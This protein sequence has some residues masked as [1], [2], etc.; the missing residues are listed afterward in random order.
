[1]AQDLKLNVSITGDF[2]GFQNSLNGLQKNLKSFGSSVE[3]V[4]RSLTSA[5]SILGG[6]AFFGK[7]IKDA[8]D[9]EETLN[10][11]NVVFKDV[12]VE[13]NNAARDLANNFGL[14]SNAART[15]LS[16][17][18]DL[19]TGFGF[20]GEAALELSTNV[21]EL[22]V[23]LASFTNFSGGAEGASAALTKALLG[24]TESLKS[25]GIAISQDAV[26]KK[27]Q[28][29]ATEGVTFAT[30]RQA[31]A[32]ATLLL[33]QEQSLNAIGDFAR[34][35]NSFANQ[36]RVLRATLENL[37]VSLGNLLLP[38]ATRIVSSFRQLIQVFANSDKEV[39]VF[40]V[41]IVALVAGLG[42]ALIVLGKLIAILGSLTT[43]FT[44]LLSPITLI[45]AAIGALGLAVFALAKRFQTFR[46]L[47]VGAVDAVKLVLIDIADV[48]NTVV[49]KAFQEFV[50]LAIRGTNLI[51]QALGRE[52]QPLLDL[53]GFNSQIDALRAG[54]LEAN[55]IAASAVKDPV[56]ASFDALGNLR[57]R[58]IELKESFV[59]LFGS[60]Q[61]AG[62]AATNSLGQ[63]NKQTK[64]LAKATPEAQAA[65]SGLANAF[66]SIA[67]GTKNAKNAFSDFAQSFLRQI[68]QMILQSTILSAIQGVVPGASVQTPG[69]SGGAATGG[70]IG[71]NSITRRFAEGGQVTG[72]G[73][74][75]SDSIVARLSNGEFVSDARTVGFFGPS[76]FQNLKR[77]SRGQ[78]QMPAFNQ[79]GFVG[80]AT[81][82]EFLSQANGTGTIEIRNTGQPKNVTRT[83]TR[84]EAQGTVTTIFLEDLERNGPINRALTRK[85]RAQR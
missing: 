47:G 26:Q 16:D 12:A 65:A 5:F 17:T 21:Q 2:K 83:L 66:T 30:E 23:D 72:P 33:A 59:G 11:F 74:G 76:F 52:I 19:L 29:L 42:P 58:A 79:G 38:V 10:K 32:Q 70:F 8:S 14:S 46:E 13:A 63:A 7:I 68:S 9:A 61:Q 39:K 85:N 84:Q 37:S 80:M 71:T 67:D 64:E 4:G 20:S 41:S 81:G 53:D 49:V 15:L 3:G 24:E 25:L 6:G 62:N 78:F 82:S 31:K 55:G 56:D 54:V 18:G 77:I 28:Q 36:T 57:N 22:A 51:N 60:A 48:I 45:I 69:I 73:T 27:V 44:V 75:T 1:M 43:V 50:N 34:S 35:Q 40:I